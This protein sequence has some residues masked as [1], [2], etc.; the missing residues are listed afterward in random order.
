VRRCTSQATA[1]SALCTTWRRPLRSAI[2]TTGR[3]SSPP[4]DLGVGRQHLRSS[5]PDDL[6]LL[7]A[8][9][10]RFVGAIQR[11]ARL[12]EANVGRQDL[13]LGGSDECAQVMMVGA[14]AKA[15]RSGDQA[16]EDVAGLD[17]ERLP[18]IAS[19]RPPSIARPCLPGCSRDRHQRTPVVAQAASVRRNLVGVGMRA[20]SAV[21]GVIAEKAC[22]PSIPRSR[23]W[24]RQWLGLGVEVGRRRQ[25]WREA[26][27]ARSRSGRS[28]DRPPRSEREGRG[29]LLS[30]QTAAERCCP[31]SHR[32]DGIAGLS[33]VAQQLVSDASGGRRNATLAWPTSYTR[34]T[35]AWPSRS[36]RR[37]EREASRPAVPAASGDP[38]H[39]GVGTCAALGPGADALAAAASAFSLA[40]PLAGRCRHIPGQPHGAPSRASC[41]TCSPAAA[42]LPCRGTARRRQARQL[43]DAPRLGARTAGWNG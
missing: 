14:G 15:C 16:E 33:P 3:P 20:R 30:A 5:G 31:S 28:F 21:Y 29:R 35:A 19:A 41:A 7:V 34:P 11:P 6:D 4:L 13:L 2:M 9:E 12:Q 17:R 23:R 39:Y 24:R 22:Q 27:I 42:H 1:S 25:R 43:L 32:R 37:C 36:A 18:R 26:G 40:A 38:F 10:A 8:Q